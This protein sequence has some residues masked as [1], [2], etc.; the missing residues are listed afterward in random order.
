MK[1]SQ[2]NKRLQTLVSRGADLQDRL[3][4][5][6][7]AAAEQVSKGNLNWLSEL[8]EAVYVNSLPGVRQF[9]RHVDKSWKGLSVKNG[10]VTRGKGP[11]EP[12][13]RLDTS[14]F[15]PF[16][17]AEPKTQ[18][19][20]VDTRLGTMLD[21]IK[22]GEYGVQDASAVLKAARELVAVLEKDISKAAKEAA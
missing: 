22:S 4:E 3:Q 19:W 6:F 2:F 12:T 18:V 9:C 15:A 14:W 11:I 1:K 8:V 10:Q 17:G 5:L 16:D 20:R 21:R 7:D 13:E